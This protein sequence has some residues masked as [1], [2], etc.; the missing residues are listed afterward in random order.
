MLRRRFKRDAKLPSW[1]RSL[2]VPSFTPF[3]K[4]EIIH[5]P[6]LPFSS[7]A[8]GMSYSPSHLPWICIPGSSFLPFGLLL[9]LVGCLRTVG[10]RGSFIHG[11]YIKQGTESQFFLS[12]CVFWR[13]GLNF[14]PWTLPLSSGRCERMLTGSNSTD[15]PTLLRR[16]QSSSTKPSWMSAS[17]PGIHVY[18]LS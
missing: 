17:L 14:C 8:A 11:C 16:S 1:L 7:T 13:S 12:R 2:R 15:A 4:S 18:P 5:S 6:H 3:L 10:R 9:L